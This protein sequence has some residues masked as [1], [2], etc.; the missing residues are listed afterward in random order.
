MTTDLWVYLS[1]ALTHVP[2]LPATRQLYEQVASVVER[3]GSGR[4]YLPHQ[5]TDPQMAADLT[6]R[7]VFDRDVAAMVA[8]G[9]VLAYTGIPSAGVGAECVLAIDLGLPL[10]AF[11]FEGDRTSRFLAG[12]L[13][14][15]GLQVV[16]LPPRTGDWTGPLGWALTTWS[17]AHTG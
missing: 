11:E 10:L 14:A 8:A 2:D 15:K 4:A 9:R 13:Q 12:F 7:E 1:G 17:S 16:R 6:A 3:H 5:N